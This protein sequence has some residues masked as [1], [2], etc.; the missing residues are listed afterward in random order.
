MLETVTPEHATRMAVPGWKLVPRMFTLTVDPAEAPEGVAD[1]RVGGPAIGAFSVKVSGLLTPLAL[2]ALMVYV[3]GALPNKTA[4]MVVGL[5]ITP[6][7]VKPEL[8]LSVA[9]PRLLPLSTTE[10]GT[11]VK[12]LGGLIPVK[13]GGPALM[14]KLRGLLTPPTVVATTLTA[15]EGATDGILKTA[16]IELALDS[17]LLTTMP[18]PAVKDARVRLL[19]VI[20]T[21]T[22]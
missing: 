21:G 14:L 6:L 18:P 22:I 4:V 2:L 16:V 19:P 7:A 5:E 11:P 10:T 8:V 12:P 9:P 13:D 1:V 20:V 17:R 3:P 15:P